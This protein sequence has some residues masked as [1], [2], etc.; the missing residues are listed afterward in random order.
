MSDKVFAALLGALGGAVATLVV[1]KVASA[2]LDREFDRASAQMLER[3]ETQ[4]R[5]EIIRTLDTE[6]PRRVD[7]EMTRQFQQMGLT[8]DSGRQLAAL[9]TLAERIHLVGVR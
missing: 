8:P 4:L 1:W 3:G 5:Q 9:L 2:Q 7:S 6:I